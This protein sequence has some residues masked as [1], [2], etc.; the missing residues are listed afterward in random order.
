[1]T[2]VLDTRLRADRDL[3]RLVELRASTDIGAWLRGLGLGQYRAAF[4]EAAID[5]ETLRELTDGDLEKLEALLGRRKRLL[6]S[7][8]ERGATD[9]P[10]GRRKS[11]RS[12]ALKGVAR[13]EATKYLA[14]RAGRGG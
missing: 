14:W 6:K 12:A 4:H 5:A 3:A 9:Q 13:R 10:P 7:I 1:V 11:F 2:D 8:A